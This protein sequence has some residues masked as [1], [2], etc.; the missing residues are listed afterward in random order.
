MD[1][2]HVKDY[3]YDASEDLR[4][5]S[6][7]EDAAAVENALRMW[8]VSFKGEHIRRPDANGYVVQWLFKPMDEDTAFDIKTAVRVGIEREFTPHIEIYSIK[9]EPDYAKESWYIEIYGYIPV[10]QEELHVIEN[11]RRQT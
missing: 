1:N 7:Y 8:L 4:G 3:A 2:S 5:I 10:L 6:V 9:V 11:L